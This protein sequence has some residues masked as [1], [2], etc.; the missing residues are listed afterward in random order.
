MEEVAMVTEG[1][2][3]GERVILTDLVPAIEGMLLVA[4]ED[5]EQTAALQALQNVSPTELN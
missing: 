4:E 2:F 5:A 1:L 3:P